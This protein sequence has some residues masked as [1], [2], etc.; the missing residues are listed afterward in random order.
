MPRY[1]LEHWLNLFSLSFLFTLIPILVWVMVITPIIPDV[2]A[3]ILTPRSSSAD[4][5]PDME[6]DV[7]ITLTNRGALVV[8]QRLTSSRELVDVMRKVPEGRTARIYAET[9]TPWR[10]IRAIVRAARAAGQARVTFMVR[11]LPAPA[12]QSFE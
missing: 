12:E 5:S 6:R 8:G 10:Y 9:G 1:D 4:K 2:P 3:F 11:P 7:S